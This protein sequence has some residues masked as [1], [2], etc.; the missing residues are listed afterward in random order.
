MK[1][2]IIVI[3]LLLTIQRIGSGQNPN[4]DRIKYLLNISTEDTSKVR[5]MSELCNQYKFNRPDSAIYFGNKGLE[6]ARK[7]D[8]PK[9]EVTIMHN[10]SLAY[11]TVGNDTRALQ[12][13][14]QG[15]K[16]AEKNSLLYDKGRLLMDLATINRNSEN[17]AKALKI[18][19]ES[20]MLF[21]QARV[22]RFSTLAEYQIAT[23]LTL[24]NELD[25]A[26]YH[27]QLANEHAEQ[28]KLDWVTGY[29]R[30]GLGQIYAKKGNMKLALSYY[31]GSL[32][33]TPDENSY[34]NL[35]IA[36]VYQ[37]IDKPDSAIYYAQSS[38]DVAQKN[39]LYRD[40]IYANN[41]LSQLFEIE[42]PR[43]ALEY[44]KSAFTANNTLNNLRTTTALEVFI[45]YNEQERQYE[46]ETAKIEFQN[47]SRL[48]ILFGT[49][50]PCW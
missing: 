34:I 17:Y 6:L 2:I 47:K 31:Q 35:A 27:G 50:L 7:I 14:L 18:Y 36:K 22:S 26:L 29:T 40:I 42:D 23:T 30:F 43:K 15:I 28:L 13:T 38:L 41:L 39:G 44:R 25:S 49:Y 11:I 16:I 46:L 32:Q 37:K 8:S 10:I 5:L 9:N 19:K 45:D 48:N 12:T 24:M 3:V 21:D 33:L 20:K 1:K 4:I